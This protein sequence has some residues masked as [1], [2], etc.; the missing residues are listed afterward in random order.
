MVCGAPATG[1]RD[2]CHG[3]KAKVKSIFICDNENIDTIKQ[4]AKY[5]LIDHDNVLQSVESLT[6]FVQ[7]VY[8]GMLEGLRDYLSMQSDSYSKSELEEITEQENRKK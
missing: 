4:M 8:P 7:E 5:E 2:I 6:A 3:S 1:R